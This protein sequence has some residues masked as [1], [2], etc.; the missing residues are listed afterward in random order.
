MRQTLKCCNNINGT[1]IFD[2]ID[3]PC[4][5]EDSAIR[6]HNICISYLIEISKDPAELC[7]EDYTPNTTT[8]ST[9][10]KQST[11]QLTT[12]T[13]T[14]RPQSP[15]FVTSAVGISICGEYFDDTGEREALVRFLGKLEVGH[16]WPTRGI[17]RVLREAWATSASDSGFLD[18]G[19]GIKGLVK[20]L[21]SGFAYS[22]FVRLF[23]WL[24]LL[25]ILVLGFPSNDSATYIQKFSDSKVTFTKQ[26]R[27][28]TVD[29]SPM[30]MAK[31]LVHAQGGEKK[32]LTGRDVSLTAV[33]NVGAGSDTTGLSLSSVVFYIYQNPR[34]LQKIREEIENTGLGSK[35]EITFR[36]VQKLP[37]L[38]AAIKEALRGAVICEI[39]LPE[40]ANFG[41]NSWVYQRNKT[42]YGLGADIYR[43]ERWLEADGEKATCMEQ[44]FMPF[45]TFD[46][47]FLTKDGSPQRSEYL[48]GKCMWF[49][50]PDN[51]YARVKRQGIATD[52]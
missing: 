22:S 21:S 38:Q 13:S 35:S 25:L 3:L 41:V 11:A 52:L 12:Q 48:P 19:E 14:L 5:S 8:P 46:F 51:L 49:V 16:A 6:Y 32:G 28:D 45:G 18:K 36:E 17:V 33:A 40:G 15:A 24:E 9:Q 50:K 31:K 42:V 4:L 27:L 7:N 29:N 44:C 34:C 2:G 20:A 37:Y 30:Y 47:G 10:R 1:V 26:E 43:P 23:R 39:F